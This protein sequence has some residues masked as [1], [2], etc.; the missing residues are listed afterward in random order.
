MVAAARNG[1]I[2]RSGAWHVEMSGQPGS[3]YF[4]GFQSVSTL[5]MERLKPIM[6]IL[7]LLP[8]M[9]PWQLLFSSEAGHSRAGLPSPGF[10][11]LDGLN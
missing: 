7:A 9:D 4:V 10:I 5:F 11:L 2:F 1:A 8:L 3:A 6:F